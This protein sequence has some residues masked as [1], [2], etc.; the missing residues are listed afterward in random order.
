MKTGDMVRFRKERF[1]RKQKNDCGIWD[2]KIGLL[3][4]YR[5]WE[6]IA[7]I[8]HEGQQ[9]RVHSSEVEKAGKKDFKIGK[10]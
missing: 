10:S 2:W 8:L 1:P 9:V 4:E 3:I 5:P 6:K 7:T